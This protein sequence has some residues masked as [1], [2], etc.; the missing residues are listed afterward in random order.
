MILV[1]PQCHNLEHSMVNTLFIKGLL[2]SSHDYNLILFAEENHLRLVSDNLD[3]INQ[4]SY[5][6]IN[7]PKRGS[8]NARRLIDELKLVT[9]IF[10]LTKKLN[11]SKIIF[12]SSTPAG[13]YCIK[14]ANNK[15]SKFI[16][17]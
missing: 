1:E 4:I 14:L 8:S 15:A 11:S 10:F 2:R 3:S 16:K 6:S 17:E 7:I 9:K 12:L 13:I 5:K